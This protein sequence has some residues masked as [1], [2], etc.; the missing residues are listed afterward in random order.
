MN[1][2]QLGAITM[3]KWGMTMEDGELAEWLI[4]EGDVVSIGQEVATVET[5]KVTGAVE[6]PVAGTVLRLVARVGEVLPVAALLAVTG[7]PE[8]PVDEIVK[9]IDGQS[10]RD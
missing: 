7:D 10:P 1:G 6:S 2:S 8:T 5:D 4:S 9:F 3:P